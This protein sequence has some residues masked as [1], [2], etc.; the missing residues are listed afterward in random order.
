MHALHKNTWQKAGIYNAVLNSSYDIIKNNDLILGFAQKW[1]QETKTFVFV[2][3][4]VSIT[5]EDMMV[6]G[7]YSVLGHSVVFDME[8]DDS[9]RAVAKLYEGI[10]ELNRSR[11]KKASQFT[12][13][14]K[15]KKSGSEI[16]HEAFLALWLSRYVFPSS[17]DVVVR[18]VCH[19]AV[20]L[21]RGNRLALAPAVLASIYRDLGF[22]RNKIGVDHSDETNVV[23]WAPFQLLQ[24]WILERFPKI[25]PNWVDSCNPRFAR[26]E[27]KKLSAENVGAIVD[28]GLE[29]F[30]W[31]PYGFVYKEKGRSVDVVGE[32]LDEELESWV[33][34]K[35]VSELVG[36]DG[37][38]M[39]QYLPHRVARQFGMNQDV[40]SDVP[41]ANLT[42]KKAWKFYNRP[43]EDVKLYIPPQHSEW[44]NK[45]NG[46]CS[47]QSPIADN[48]TE[49]FDKYES[50]TVESKDCKGDVDI[51][52]LGLLELEGRISKL[53][54]LFA[55]LKA[56]KNCATC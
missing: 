17:N 42:H 43:I 34:C 31:Q 44:W 41:R 16:E 52:T 22:L 2:W 9:E 28:C 10:A 47:L 3:G 53:E 37:K 13:M 55:Y 11:Q 30:C 14:K 51:D 33:R 48:A 23:V 38:C 8:D 40:P 15:F 49:K 6:F 36:I 12:W 29:D 21:A 20:S 54:E 46:E 1:C 5:L 7:G 24:V 27:K 32:C 18:N 50:R 35:R 45:S 4:E 25:S 56:K 26:W 39:E 19:I